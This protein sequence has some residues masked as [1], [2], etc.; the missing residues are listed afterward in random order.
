ML[1]EGL[2]E[3]EYENVDEEGIKELDGLLERFL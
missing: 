1:V 2:T 3:D